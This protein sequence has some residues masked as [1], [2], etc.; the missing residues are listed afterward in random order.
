MTFKIE[1]IYMVNQK[2]VKISMVYETSKK[3]N[4]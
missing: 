2:E 4:F 3:I 1:K